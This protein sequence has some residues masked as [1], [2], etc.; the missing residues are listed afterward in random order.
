VAD[1]R[2][3]RVKSKYRPQLVTDWFAKRKTPTW[4]QGLRIQSFL[5][6]RAKNE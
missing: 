4:E 1:V 5:Q 3:W 6:G 2:G